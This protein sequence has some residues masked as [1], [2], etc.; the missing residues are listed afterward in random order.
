MSVFF[1][2]YASRRGGGR[3]WAA[4][5]KDSTKISISHR[6]VLRSRGSRRDWIAISRFDMADITV[7][8]EKW[9]ESSGTWNTY[10]IWYTFMI[11]F[12]AKKIVETPYLEEYL[13]DFKIVLKSCLGRAQ[14]GIFYLIKHGRNRIGFSRDGRNIK[15][16]NGFSWSDYRNQI[17]VSLDF[18]SVREHHHNT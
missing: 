1:D 15:R 2:V 7:F 11:Q 4:K 14:W 18:I 16:I 13:I 3:L 10:I 9:F 6:P 8:P 5:R 12:D 17:L